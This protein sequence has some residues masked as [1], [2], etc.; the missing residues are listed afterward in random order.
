MIQLKR[1]GEHS[2]PLPKQETL[3]AAG[4]DLATVMPFTLESGES[5][6]VN[7]GFAW[8]IPSGMAGMI[9]PRSGLAVRSGIDIMAGVIDSDYRGEVCAVLVNHSNFDITFRA[10]DR[11][12]QMVIQ[13]CCTEL[14]EE[15]ETLPGTARGGLGFGSTGAQ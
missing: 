12:A 3:G 8:A 11:I 7:T 1:I 9:R 13:P 15:C 14:T 10:G 2:L 5:A 4:Y 6:S